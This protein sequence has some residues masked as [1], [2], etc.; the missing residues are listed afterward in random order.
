MQLQDGLRN[1]Q[2]LLE[3]KQ[4]LK[5]QVHLL[6][7]AAEAAS[8]RSERE[9]SSSVA[10]AGGLRQTVAMLTTQLHDATS[11]ALA[12]QTQLQTQCQ[13]IA[14][15]RSQVL[16]AER[17]SAKSLAEHEERASRMASQTQLLQE[18]ASTLVDLQEQAASNEEQVA[19]LKESLSTSVVELSRKLEVAAAK[20]QEASRCTQAQS[21]EKEAMAG[22]MRALKEVLDESQAKA[23]RTEGERRSLEAQLLEVQQDLYLA[24]ITI[25]ENRKMFE[26]LHMEIDSACADKSKVERELGRMQ[27]ELAASIAAHASSM[28]ENTSLNLQ[29]L[30]RCVVLAEIRGT[31]LCGWPSVDLMA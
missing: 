8:Q 22:E 20:L 23:A 15:L 5:A 4:A 31:A 16:D 28:Q 7:E 17:K 18:R 26:E 27:G 3:H 9:L 14:D 1:V 2:G 25:D 24:E 30:V 12:A 19:K 10:E 29:L 11:E 21:E 6:R 13:E